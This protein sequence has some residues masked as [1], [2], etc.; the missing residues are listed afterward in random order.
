M[1]FGNLFVYFQFQGQESIDLDTRTVVFWTLTAV[2]IV[3]IIFLVL[4]RKPEERD[5]LPSQEVVGPLQAL[6]NAGRMAVTRDML[7]LC[8]TFFYTGLFKKN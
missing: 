5:D 1:F 6:V 7:L 8:V 3:G 2:S 4:L